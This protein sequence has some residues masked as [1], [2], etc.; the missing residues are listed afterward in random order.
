MGLTEVV[1]SEPAISVTDGSAVTQLTGWISKFL[2]VAGPPGTTSAEASV[3][4]RRGDDERRV[5]VLTRENSPAAL[6]EESSESNLGYAT[7]LD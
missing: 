5:P 6:A 3:S 4:L 2:T 7:K 1:T